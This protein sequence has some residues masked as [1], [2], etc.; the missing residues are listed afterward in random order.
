MSGSNIDNSISIKVAQVDV[1]A[2]TGWV[3]PE[4]IVVTYDSA[5]R[6]ITLTH[7]TALYYYYQGKKYNKG[8]TWTSTAHAAS[9]GPYFL[10]LDSTGASFWHTTFPGF[11]NGVYVAFVNYGATDKFAIREVHGLMPWQ[12]WKECHETIGTYYQSGGV[13]V[14]GSYAL[15]T[16]TVAALTPGTTACVVAD[17]DLI[18]TVNALADGGPYT[19]LHF[20]SSVAVFT[21]GSTFPYASNGTNP[22][23]NSGGTSLVAITNNSN[24]VNCYAIFVPVTADAGSQAYRVVWMTGQ[25]LHGTLAAAQAEDFRANNLGNLANLF[26]EFLPRIRFSFRRDSTYNLTQNTRLDSDPAYITGTKQGLVSISGVVP[27][28]HTALA[29]RTT[30][31]SHPASAVSVVA[32]GFSGALSPTDT[33]GQTAL[34][35]LDQAKANRYRVALTWSGAGPY[36]MTITAATHGKGLYPV[37]AVRE[38][39]TTNSL[40][41]GTAISTVTASGDVT[42]TSVTNFTGDVI[43]L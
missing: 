22:Q 17:E 1:K 23:Y 9:N 13:V 32:A 43:I 10:T 3:D 8:T 20:I 2:P 36:T 4:N 18:S 41:V 30:A 26:T 37:V 7:S 21:T 42:I 16:K 34:A 29:D 28:S 11:D 33:D 25:F 40:N 27:S 14:P 39:V 6:T 31:D 24:W 15:D 5:A 38:T 12:S 35:T 19:R